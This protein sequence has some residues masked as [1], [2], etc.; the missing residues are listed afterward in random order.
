MKTIQN[1]LRSVW[2][3]GLVLVWLSGAAAADSIG[4]TVDTSVP[5]DGTGDLPPADL[6]GWFFS[7]DPQL[8]FPT[9]PDPSQ[10]DLSQAWTSPENIATLNYWLGLVM[11]LGDDPSLLAQLYGLGMISSPD[12]ATLMVS[13]VSNQESPSDIPEPATLPLFIGGLALLGLNA[14]ERARR[15]RNGLIPAAI[16][17]Y[18]PL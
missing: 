8:P 6:S 2:L 10:P 5:A 13:Q 12:P 17:G 3:A 4:G 9:E 1:G 11:E 14:T 16:I 7:L 18:G 15:L